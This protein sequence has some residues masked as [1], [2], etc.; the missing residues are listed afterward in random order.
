[1]KAIILH[2]QIFRY[3]YDYSITRQQYKLITSWNIFFHNQKLINQINNTYSNFKH[4]P[5]KDMHIM[6][7]CGL[8]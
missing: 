3:I 2:N 5:I 6:T 1:M 8:D 7:I 4:K